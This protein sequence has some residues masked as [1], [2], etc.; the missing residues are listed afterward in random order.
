MRQIKNC[1]CGAEAKLKY[2]FGG[3]NTYVI[4]ECTECGTR[5]RGILAGLAPLDLDYALSENAPQ[6]SA[7]E[8]VEK[9]DAL[10][11]DLRPDSEIENDVRA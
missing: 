3:F 2:S 10:L 4:V 6:N 9:W 11:R 7:D 5:C 1:V 8:A